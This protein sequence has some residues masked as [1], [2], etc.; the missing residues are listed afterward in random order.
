MSAGRGGPQRLRIAPEGAS[1]TARRVEQH[2][3]EQTFVAPLL[4]IGG[5]DLR[6]ERHALQ[7]LAHALQ[8]R[9]GTIDRR[10]HRS[11]V[12]EL[13]RL[14][15]GRR[16]QIAR[17]LVRLSVQQARREYGGGVLHPPGRPPAARPEREDPRDGGC[18]GFLPGG[19]R[20]PG[21]QPARRTLHLARRE[22]GRRFLAGRRCDRARDLVAVETA[23]ALPQPVRQVGLRRRLRTLARD[24]A[25][26]RVDQALERTRRLR[27]LGERH[28]RRHRGEVGHI[29]RDQLQRPRRSRSTTASGGGLCKRASSMRSMR[30]RLRSTAIAAACARRRLLGAEAFEARI[31]QRFVE[32]LCGAEGGA[33]QV[34]RR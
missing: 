7:I 1:G 21:R 16:A 32:D 12:G 23:P 5:N 18:A 4:R 27:A 19:A 14:A 6:G 34:D 33:Q 11:R 26:H 20:P 13:Q 28:G 25:Q 17:G 31:V 29:E 9:R 22:I 3:V 8:S 2:R 24:T 15:A 30:P 10:D